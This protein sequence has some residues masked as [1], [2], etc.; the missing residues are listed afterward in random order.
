M[1]KSIVTAAAFLTLGIG[2]AFAGQGPSSADPRD[3]VLPED[4]TS[5][6]IPRNTQARL[7]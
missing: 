1:M 4:R 2:S 6:H 3:M 7:Q 5:M